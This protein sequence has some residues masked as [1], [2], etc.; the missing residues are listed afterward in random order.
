MPSIPDQQSDD[1]ALHMLP[2]Q[3][4][5]LF[6]REVGVAEWKEWATSAS[7][8]LR[9]ELAAKRVGFNEA[10]HRVQWTVE[11]PRESGM[12]ALM[13]A[14][15]NTT[16]FDALRSVPHDL[17][18]ALAQL[19]ARSFI[20]VGAGS[21]LVSLP[22]WR[23]F[24]LI[25]D[26]ESTEDMWTMGRYR[27]AFISVSER[28]TPQQRR[29]IVEQAANML[30]WMAESQACPVLPGVPS[31]ASASAPSSSPTCSGSRSLSQ[32]LSFTLLNDMGDEQLSTATAAEVSRDYSWNFAAMQRGYLQPFL[33]RVGNYVKL[34]VD[35]SVRHYAA[36]TTESKPVKLTGKGSRKLPQ[37]STN[38][39]NST[40]RTTNRQVWS[41]PS[42]AL[43]NLIGSI[44]EWNAPSPLVSHS[45][46]LLAYIPPPE[47]RPLV[48]DFSTPGSP[49]SAAAAARHTALFVS[50][51]GGVLVLNNPGECDAITQGACPLDPV[52]VKEIMQTFVEQIRHAIGLST[53][54]DQVSE[55]QSPPV[56]TFSSESSR[57]VIAHS[58]LDFSCFPSF[59]PSLGVP[60][61]APLL[62]A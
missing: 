11:A 20:P 30:H 52:A 25:P 62:L 58:F 9:Q 43:R 61:S 46:E 5:V 14:A 42:S 10:G 47:H 60:F 49:A 13:S 29:S 19:P 38:G 24:V 39:G 44:G 45:M 57:D 35:S 59:F 8:L 40:N 54:T 6:A 2:L 32:R 48:I 3:L 41:L 34:E 16:S 26:S 31:S 33:D 22:L 36:L 55:G 27:H 53:R 1:T 15:R 21:S 17:D 18:D 7:E 56:A 23:L 12:A 50:Q 28:R 51:F 4:H 37:T